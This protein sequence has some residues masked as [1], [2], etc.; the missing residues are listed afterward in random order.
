MTNEREKRTADGWVGSTMPGW[1]L[2]Q[3]LDCDKYDPKEMYEIAKKE[4]TDD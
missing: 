3:L 4:D 1:Y 2:N